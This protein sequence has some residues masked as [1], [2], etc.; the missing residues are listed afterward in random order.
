MT[1]TI[2]G[3]DG[4]EYGPITANDM[5]QWLA[6]GRL[7][8]QSLAKAESDAEFR[9][10]AQFPEFADAFPSA[11]PE[12]IAPLPSSALSDGDYELDIGNCV[13]SGWALLKEKF[14]ILFA[15]ALIAL[16]TVFAAGFILGLITSPLD[17]LLS[18]ASVAAEVGFKFLL[19]L[20]TSLVVGPIFGGLYFV[21][22]KMIRGQTASVGE[23]FAGFQKAFG[24]LYLGAAVVGLITSVF[25]LP[26]Q[27]V[28]QLK[29]TPLLAQL[30]QTQGGHNSSA[31]IQNLQNVSHDLLHAYASALPVLLVCLIPMTYLTVSLQFTLPLIMD[32]GLP[33]WAAIKT[34]FRR[35]N[36]H[37]WQVFGLTV[38]VGLISGAGVLLCCVGVLF[39]VPLGFAISLFAYETI[40]SG[41]QNN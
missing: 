8:A 20:V 11:A 39:T 7:N 10:L 25:L 13:T 12:N 16:V 5:R 26:F 34:S 29:I 35:V 9:A 21:F 2:I 19:P 37:W 17:K 15:V 22:L 3:G 33:F 41:R 14:G 32:K 40:F 30:Q 27:Y 28:V 38:V 24:Q 4:K 18:R 31:D 6:E 1:Y 23:V 36:K